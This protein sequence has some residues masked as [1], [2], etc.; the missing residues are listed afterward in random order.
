MLLCEPKAALPY[1]KINRRAFFRFSLRPEF[2]V[3]AAND[4]FDDG[5]SYSCTLELRIG[6]EPPKREK[7][8]VRVCRMETGQ[9]SLT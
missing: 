2:S 3:A 1:R 8:F 6:M 5:K 4:P 9:S 7:H